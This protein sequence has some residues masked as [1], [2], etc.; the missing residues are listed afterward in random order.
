MDFGGWKEKWQRDN[1]KNQNVSQENKCEDFMGVCPNCKDTASWLKY[2]QTASQKPDHG[3]DRDE[4]G[5]REKWGEEKR[6][7]ERCE[8]VSC[9]QL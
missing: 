7:E 5:E 3:E 1:L 6:G 9:C 4:G 2:L 8:L